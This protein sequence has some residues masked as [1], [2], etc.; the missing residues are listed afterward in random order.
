MD[1]GGSNLTFTGVCVQN[2]QQQQQA[3]MAAAAGRGIGA[4][5]ASRRVIIIGEDHHRCLP[6]LEALESLGVPH[7]EWN[8]TMGGLIP[9]AIPEDAVYYCRQSPSAG[10]REH[11]ASID[12]VRTLLWWLNVHGCTIV[13]GPTAFELEMSKAAQM[14]LLHQTG[15]NTPRSKLVVG[16]Q[17]LWNELM[18]GAPDAPVIVKPNTG[19]SGHGVQAFSSAR[20]AAAAVRAGDFKSSGV[21]TWLVQEHLGSYSDHPDHIRSILRFE[22]VGGKV[23]YVTQVRAPATEFSLCPCNPEL[24]RVLS[25]M[26]FRIMTD[27]LSIP[28]FR[29]NAAGYEA[30]CNKLEMA[31]AKAGALVGSVEAFL[32]TAYLDDAHCRRYSAE[33]CGSPSEPVVVDMNFNSNYNSSAEALVGLSGMGSI[34]AMLASLAAQTR[35]EEDEDEEESAGAGAGGHNYEDIGDV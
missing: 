8:V 30:F 29:D 21:T 34:A 3:H 9:T 25:R 24:K 32:P 31:W 28:C 12:Y 13:N 11:G 27:P 4:G 16:L 5:H 6:L 20:E 23:Y 33:A 19:G 22:I 7:E 15:I 18:V 35:N 14:A 10:M 17:Q 1:F 2:E 26:E